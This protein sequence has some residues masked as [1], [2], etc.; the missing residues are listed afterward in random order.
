MARPQAADGGD[1]LHT[2]GSCDYIE[3]DVADNR[4]G[5]DPR[6]WGWANNSSL[7]K[8]N[9]LQNTENRTV[10]GPLERRKQRQMDLRFDRVLAGKPEGRRPL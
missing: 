7:Q 6:L 3:Q 8:L 9:M 1:G 5:V 4:Q 2:E 10:I